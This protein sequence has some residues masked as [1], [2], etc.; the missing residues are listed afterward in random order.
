[1]EIDGF[2]KLQD[3]STRHI[4]AQA[5]VAKSMADVATKI[6]T[7]G[8]IHEETVKLHLE[9]VAKFLDIQWDVQAH[10]HLIKIRN[11]AQMRLRQSR[12]EWRTARAHLFR[13]GALLAGGGSWTTMRD[14]WI[15]FD[16]L[17]SHSPPS[18]LAKTGSVVPR[19]GAYR[20]SAWLHPNRKAVQITAQ[21]PGSLLT[22]ARRETCFPM[23]GGDAWRYVADYLET[24]E[25]AAHEESLAIS[26][27]ID[28]AEKSALELSKLDWER[29]KQ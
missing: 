23:M 18:V 4:E 14:A 19:P 7:L 6:A 9:N 29:L 16:Y 24:L 25:R 26:A 8:L 17:R 27:S 20:V 21:D 3:A 12:D 22:W 11:M 1:M 5:N 28:A 10:K 2:V 15:A 13:V